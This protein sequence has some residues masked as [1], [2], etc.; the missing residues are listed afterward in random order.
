P[1]YVEAE[2]SL[3]ADISEGQAALRAGI[4]PAATRGA[5][6]AAIR[7][8]E[9]QLT[10]LRLRLTTD[11]PAIAALRYPRLW[12]AT[13]LA[14]Q[15]LRPDQALVA[16]FLGP[17][18]SVAWLIDRSGTR[19]TRLPAEADIESAAR[20]YLS[21]TSVPGRGGEPVLAASLYRA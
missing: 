2:A 9:E 15:I 3:L 7:S 6:Q 11:L 4:V 10:A 18:G 5:L 19:M 8:D 20:A 13:D 21:A 16:F 12:Q 14:A 1:A 17:S